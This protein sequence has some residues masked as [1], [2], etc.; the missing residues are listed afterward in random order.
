MLQPDANIDLD[1][2][3]FAL[4]AKKAMAMPQEGKPSKDRPN[5][6]LDQS[7]KMLCDTH[8]APAVFFSNKEERYVCFKCLVSSE[9]LLYIDKSYK[10]EMEYFEKVKEMT[11]LAIKSNQ[12]NLNIM[13]QW[14]YQIRSCLMKIKER[15]NE[16]ID[17]FIY[18]FGK[19]FKNVEQSN[20]LIKFK[21]EDRRLQTQ[22]EELELKYQEVQ[23]IFSNIASSTAQKR[24]QYIDN[25][26]SYMKALE[27]RVKD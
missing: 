7:I 10:M 26:K 16:S 18:E 17:K 4:F 24:I 3:N 15:F 23:K 25:I 8:K 9:K 13:K 27:K 11:I 12:V 1:S 2:D 21:G 5:E 20:E 22:V 19:V 14:K 6:I